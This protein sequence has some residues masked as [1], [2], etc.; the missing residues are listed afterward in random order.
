MEESSANI[1]FPEKSI[2]PIAVV[3]Q[4]LQTVTDMHHI[5]ELLMWMANIMVQRFHAS[6]TQMWALQA[7]SSG[8]VSIRLR[9]NVCQY[10]FQDLHVL[11]GA[12][13]RA[14]VE[15]KLREKQGILSVPVTNIFSSQTVPVLIMQNCR[16][17]TMYFLSNDLFLPPPRKQQE[18]EEVYTPLQMLFTFFTKE[19]L[20]A[21]QTRAI[22]FLVEQSLRIA[23]SHGLLSKFPGKR[24][25]VVQ[26]TLGTLVP[27]HVQVNEIEQA[28]N[29]FSHTVV[30]AEKKARQMYNV[31][32]GKKNIEEV[33]ALM[34]IEKREAVEILQ[35]LLMKK[36]IVLRER[37]GA[38][39]ELS[40]LSQVFK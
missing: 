22:S 33:A 9:A 17:C 21:S 14:F 27:E 12:E 20:E 4:L 3:S 18:R 15:R 39:V 16:Y 24:E 34:H 13:V 31:I 2:Q 26:Q 40:S 1:R 25:E 30:I 35:F 28:S 37:G 5:D 23:L 32:D 38:I 6:A 11:E 36:Y 29:P 19:P 7:S 10:V 8:E